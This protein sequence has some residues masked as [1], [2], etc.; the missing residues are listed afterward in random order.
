M[1]ESENEFKA[2]FEFSNIGLG[3][4]D[5]KG[6]FIKI[7]HKLT[8][9][10]GYEESFLLKKNCIHISTDEQREE[11][12]CLFQKLIDKEIKNYN[13]EKSYIKKDGTKFE[14]ILT[15]A[16]I[17][18]TKGNT[19]HILS[20]IIDV[21]EIKEKD[22]LLIQQSKMAT[23]GEMIGNIAHQWK[24]PLSLISM[25]NGLVKLNQEDNTF[26]SKEEIN[27]A[28]ANIDNSVQHLS[29]T[30][31]DFRNFFMPDKAKKYF[32]L[33][34]IFDKTYK[35]INPQLKN[36]T[37]FI[38]EK[39]DDIE[40]YGYQNELLQVLINIIKNA[41]DELIKLDRDKKRLLFISMYIKNNQAFI[42]IKDTAGGIPLDI[43]DNIFKAYF[44]TKESKEGTGIGLY[45]SK[46]IIEGMGGV[47]EVSN[48]EYEYENENYIGA[49]F[50]IKLPL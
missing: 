8:D 31:D 23:M 32:N 13:I 24:Q 27:E 26:S 40:V 47:I 22:R 5:T 10:L 18:D 15:M 44:T 17:L 20:S 35:L 38:L 48:T 21:S 49:E 4:R 39:I 36:N 7:N 29:S 6:N 14:A 25:S 30:I 41:K 34:S 12:L 43:I 37:I 3:I 42:K 1:K 2:L 28:L 16:A 9:M 45:M 50:I 11:E 19:T 46:Q 33:R